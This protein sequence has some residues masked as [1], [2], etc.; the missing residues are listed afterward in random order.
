MDANQFQQLLANL[1][2]SFENAAA[3]IVNGLRP[4]NMQ[5]NIIVK[6]VDEVK[7]VEEVKDNFEAFSVDDEVQKKDWKCY[8]EHFDR[9]KYETVR[10]EADINND[11]IGDNAT[12]NVV[13]SHDYY[14]FQRT[15]VE[16][17][18]KPLIT[19]LQEILRDNRDIHDIE[20]RINARVLFHV[21][22]TLKDTA[23]TKA[24]SNLG[25]LNSMIKFLE[26][27]HD[28]TIK[29]K[30]K[31]LRDK[32]VS[33]DMLWSTLVNQSR[34]KGVRYRECRLLLIYHFAIYLF[35]NLLSCVWKSYSHSQCEI[36]GQKL[37]GIIS[38]TSEDNNDDRKKIFTIDIKIIDYDSIGFKNCTIHRKIE[39]FSGVKSFSELSVILARFINIQSFKEELIKNGKLFFRHSLG[40]N[41]FLSYKGPLLRWKSDRRNKREVEKIR[42]DG[43]VIID[44]K[45]FATMN[46][47]Y[48]MENALPPNKYQYEMNKQN[49]V[50]LKKDEYLKEDSC[51]RAPAVVYGFSLALKIWGQFEVTKLAP[52][53][54]NKRAFDYLVISDDKKKL[55]KGLVKQYS[56]TTNNDG[57]DPITNKGNSCVIL[58]HGPPGTGKTLT[59]ESVAE[60]LR[61]PLWMLGMHELGINPE[62]LEKRLS[63]VLEIAY[64]WKAILLL[65]EADIYLEKRNTVDLSRNMMVGAFLRQLE[66]YQGILFLTTN[67]GA[68]FDDAICSRISMF[69]YFPKHDQSQRRKIWTIFLR[70][71]SLDI[72]ADD[73]LVEYELNGREIRNILHIARMLAHNS[74]CDL[75]KDFMISLIE[76]YINDLKE[77]RKSDTDTKMY[78]NKLSF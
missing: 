12:F 75:T 76:G 47:D 63:R 6:E 13:Y 36:S 43:R 65:D 23:M 31:M 21:I 33:F 30:D 50:Y 14:G 1:T 53:D 40:E 64:T 73:D 20:P 72:K 68:N 62:E 41:N 61:R 10:L 7:E 54:F 11:P 4:E 52:I 58:C 27:E 38:S 74:E 51:F 3:N 25:C 2:I 29:A 78:S 9:Q 22:K 55:L 16:L 70:R 42:A 66:Y 60:S 24:V 8:R 48:E 46:P 57:L 15:F 69:F 32:N 5:N 17:K 35:I 18:S 56:R 39:Y 49:K 37:G 59:A 67:R 45:S 34:H 26:H 19:I 71:A 44:L 77:L 28:K